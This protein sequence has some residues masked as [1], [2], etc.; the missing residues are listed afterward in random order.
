[1]I[2]SESDGARWPGIS[3]G[4]TEVDRAIGLDPLNAWPCWM[5]EYCLS[6]ARRHDEVIAQQKRTKELDPYLY[7]LDSWVG[8]AYR[9]KGMY[10]ESVAEYQRIQQLTGT[11]IA[12]LAITY[13][14]MGKTAESQNILNEILQLSKRK[15]VTPEHIAAIYASLGNKEEAFVWMDKAYEARTGAL[16]VTFASPIFDP[17]RSDPR[18]TALLKKMRLDQ[19]IL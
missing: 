12:G 2:S 3:V 14:R 8:L 9:E 7:Y 13:A 16:P 10:A 1:M 5:R 17:L 18:F 11:P 15:Y 6:V 4:N 19:P